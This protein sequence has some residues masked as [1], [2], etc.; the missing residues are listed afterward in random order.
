M[1]EVALYLQFDKSLKEYIR[2]DH[3]GVAIN[4]GPSNNCIGDT[5]NGKRWQILIAV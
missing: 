2:W 1:I 3:L 4:L 5:S